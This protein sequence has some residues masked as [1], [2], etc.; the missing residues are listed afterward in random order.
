MSTTTEEGGGGGSTE[1]E[2]E[3]D[4]WLAKDKEEVKRDE[5]GRVGDM[6]ST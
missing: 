3:L 5:R 4:L 2:D 1:A 6:E